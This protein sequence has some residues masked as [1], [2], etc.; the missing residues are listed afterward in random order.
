MVRAASALRME[1]VLAT[2]SAPWA[3]TDLHAELPVMPAQK[4]T[5]EEADAHANVLSVRPAKTDV[6]ACR[7]FLGSTPYVSQCVRLAAFAAAPLCLD[8]C[9]VYWLVVTCSQCCAAR[10]SLLQPVSPAGA[11]AR[12]G[13]F[14]SRQVL[15]TRSAM[16]ARLRFSLSRRTPPPTP[17]STSALSRCMN[18][19]VI[20][21]MGN[22]RCVPASGACSKA[23]SCYAG[24]EGCVALYVAARSA[25]WES[26]LDIHNGNTTL[27]RLNQA[28]VLLSRAHVA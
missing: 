8:A 27:C 23:G 25:C 22:R 3:A 16:A 18:M 13:S 14:P 28:A 20:L 17:M 4:I 5:T 6:R 19:L 12:R 2:A 11:G 1:N 21:S 15:R 26:T 24:K 10:R 9:L 7:F